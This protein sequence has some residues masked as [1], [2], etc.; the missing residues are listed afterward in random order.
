MDSVS[1]DSPGVLSCSWLLAP[2]GP[3]GL[4][5]VASSG[6]AAS[7]F[8]LHVLLISIIY[9]AG[10]YFCGIAGTA[11]GR[12]LGGLLSRFKQAAGP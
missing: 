2:L 12:V 1:G 7:L 11:T 6:A 8:L 5:L 4:G 10:A 3:V 9:H